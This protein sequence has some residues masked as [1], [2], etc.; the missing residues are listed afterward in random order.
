VFSEL[1]PALAMTVLFTLLTG[2]AYPLSMTGAAQALFPDQ[3]NG[4]LIVQDGRVIGSSLIGRPSPIP[5]IS[6]AGPPPPATATMPRPRAAAI[7]AR[8]RE[9]LSSG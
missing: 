2:I 9:S 3:A 5:A 6:T 4:S 7:S 1:R 8:H